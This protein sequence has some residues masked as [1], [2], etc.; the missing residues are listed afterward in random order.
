[1]NGPGRH[2]V[3][4]AEDWR[5]VAPLVAAGGRESL[6]LGDVW[7]RTMLQAGMA[8]GERPRFVFVRRGGQPSLGLPLARRPGAGCVAL[9]NAYTCLWRPL[10]EDLHLADAIAVGRVL[11]RERLVRLDAIPAEW[12][13]LAAFAAGLREAGLAVRCFRHFVNW[14][15]ELGGRS[16]ETYLAARP[17]ALRSTLRRQGRKARFAL[18]V[19]SEPGATLEAAIADYETIY[20]RSWKEPEPFAAFNPT[21]MRNLAGAG[22]LRLGLLRDGARP[23]AAQLWAL[24]ADRRHATVLK[25]AHDERDRAASPG[26]LLTAA[27]LRRLIDEEGIAS[28]DFGRGDDGYKRLWAGERRQRIGLLV[29]DWRHPKGLGALLRHRAGRIRA[30]LRVLYA[31]PASAQPPEPGDAP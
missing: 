25:L 31:P 9:A 1:M 11:R 17:G 19:V 23:V 21:L 2:D 4:E 29:A 28:F 12:P 27:M 13:G 7:W 3:E 5:D 20:A 15:E 16:W 18:D 24:R 10:A 22:L 30:R 26:S 8:A 6:F 14:H